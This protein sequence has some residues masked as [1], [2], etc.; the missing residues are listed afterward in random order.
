MDLQSFEGKLSG[1]VQKDVK[2]LANFVFQQNEKMRYLLSNLD[3]TNFNDL[4]LARYENGRLQI[5]TQEVN[6][7]AEKL[8]AEFEDADQKIKNKMEADVGGLR[9][10]VEQEIEGLGEW[11]ADVELTAQGIQSTVTSHTSSIENLNTKATS[12]QSQ[13]TQNANSISLVVSNGSINA[14]SIVTSI[15]NAASSVKISAD[16]VN[17]SGFVTFSDLANEGATTIN[18]SNIVSGIIEGVTF[19]TTGSRYGQIVIANNLIQVG[20]GEIY[21]DGLGTTNIVD[22]AVM[23]NADGYIWLYVGGAG[24]SWRIGS[25][26]IYFCDASGTPTSYVPTTEI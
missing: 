5:Y 3:V 1:D 2:M 18:G 12:L 11:I 4:G 26:G 24:K 13:I 22:S 15:N 20:T 25:N 23:L 19:K 17:I 10:E 16:H 21:N 9:T 6:L 14:A 7:K 8:T